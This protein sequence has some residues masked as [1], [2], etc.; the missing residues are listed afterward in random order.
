MS[1]KYFI[2]V[3]ESGTNKQERYFGV[4]CLLVP[5]SKIGLYYQVLSRPIERIYSKVIEKNSELLQQLDVSDKL[6]FLKG[7]MEKPYEAKFKNIN[8]STFEQY[9][10]LITDYFR[11][12][13]MRFCCLI[14]DKEKDNPPTEMS[15][16]QIY[17]QRL[18]LLLRNN[19]NEADFVLLPDN[20]TTPVGV[21]YESDLRKNLVNK[22]SKNCFGVHRIE[23]HSSV[24]LQMVDV[25]TGAVT[26]EFKQGKKE[27]KKAVVQKIKEKIGR[28]SLVC[29][30]TKNTPNY[31]SVW[32]KT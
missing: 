31:F 6:K 25:L 27:C 8:A 17:L 1:E 21:D 7:R 16:Y 28:S 9:R 5:V 20:I 13:D 4:G 32:L 19:V 18:S 12:D 26:Y 30:F 22:Y 29:D 15:Y 23:S 10:R 11:C 14:I 3:D 24:F 2:F